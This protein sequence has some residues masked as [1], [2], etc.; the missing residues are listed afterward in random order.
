MTEDDFR[1]LRRWLKVKAHRQIIVDRCKRWHGPE[2]LAVLGEI[3]PSEAYAEERSERRYD[4]LIIAIV[5]GVLALSLTT[6][7]VAMT[8]VWSHSEPQRALARSEAVFETGDGERK[9]ITLPDGGVIIMNESSRLLV[10]FIPQRR[11]VFML[12]GEATIEVR[13]DPHRPFIVYAGPRQF[14][15]TA[16]FAK[17]DVS[18]LTAETSRLIVASGQVAVP[19]SQ[20]SAA[21]SAALIRQQVSSG[22][23]KFLENEIGSIGPSWFTSAT[24]QMD[25]I[26][27]RLAWTRNLNL[28]CVTQSGTV[29]SYRVCTA[30]PNTLANT[31]N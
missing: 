25:E 24:V 10:G 6:V 20:V 2:I 11:E 14:D 9:S 8:R 4:R 29:G 16:G 15:V 22:G 27:R 21:R 26:N 28:Q 13:E 18:R 19:E 23:H 7:L 12:Q 5:F 31:F 17:F 1:G 3:I 30:S